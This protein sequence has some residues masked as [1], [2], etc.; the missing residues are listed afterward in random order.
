MLETSESRA[1]RVSQYRDGCFDDDDVFM[2][3]EQDDLLKVR[4]MIDEALK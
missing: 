1:M 4:S 3:F 2:V